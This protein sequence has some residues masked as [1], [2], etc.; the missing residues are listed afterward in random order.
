VLTNT[1]PEHCPESQL[2]YQL[3]GSDYEVTVI[4]FG[5]GVFNSVSFSGGIWLHRLSIL[6]PWLFLSSFA[7]ASE[8]KR[9]SS[10]RQFEA[11]HVA[12][13]DRALKRAAAASK[14][15]FFKK[16]GAKASA[17]PE[18]EIFTASSSN[19]RGPSL[20]PAV[21]PLTQNNRR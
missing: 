19:E 8:L 12:A 4:C 13:N 17:T 11:I 1:S 14:L 16:S 15:P 3:A 9:I 18:P 2:I 5:S 7:V 21:S 10:R 20:L 6:W